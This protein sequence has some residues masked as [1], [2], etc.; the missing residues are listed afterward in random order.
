MQIEEIREEIG[1]YERYLLGLN[2]ATCTKLVVN[3]IARISLRLNEIM[4]R[5]EFEG[6]AARR[7]KDKAREAEF[8]KLGGRG[9]KMF[10][11]YV[12]LAQ[13]LGVKV[14]P[15]AVKEG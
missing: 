1:R 3:S 10:N 5:I 13:K 9:L 8:A 4:A 7:R 15:I 11:G 6:M 2:A 12:E 14:E